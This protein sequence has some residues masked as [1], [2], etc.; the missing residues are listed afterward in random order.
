MIQ[1]ENGS[2]KTSLLRMLIGL[3]PPANGTV[4][5]NGR[6]I[7]QW[8]NE[9]GRELLYCGHAPGLK[10]ELSATENL[11]FNSNLANVTVGSAAVQHAL[12]HAGLQGREHLPVRVLSQGQKRRVN[13]ASLLLQK[14]ALWVLDEPLA[15]LDAQ[16][17]QWV[18]KIIDRH[19]SEGGL[20]VLTTHHDIALAC[21]PQ[22]IQVGK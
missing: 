14:R 22:V 19:L 13:L 7:K 11:H 9:Y 1:G 18:S 15:A 5:W 16:A 6:P 4:C 2:G 17:M 20:A 21:P 12:H 3:T 8:G 10:E